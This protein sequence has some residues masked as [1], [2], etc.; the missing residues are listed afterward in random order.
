MAAITT[1]PGAHHDD[2]D[3]STAS[4][5]EKK[6]LMSWLVTLDHKRIGIMYLISVTIAFALGGVFALLV[7]AEL[8]TRG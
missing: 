8:F 7:R 4:F 5:L 2:V 6:G 3:P 1:T